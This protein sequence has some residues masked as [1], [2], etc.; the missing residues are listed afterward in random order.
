MFELDSI[1][2]RTRAQ[3]F[4]STLEVLIFC[5]LLRP[6]NGPFCWTKDEQEAL[7]EVSIVL[8]ADGELRDSPWLL[9]LDLLEH[10]LFYNGNLF[11]ES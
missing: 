8:A 11:F 5:F 7:T 10:V 6:G 3:F 1:N 9:Y 4:I 2:L